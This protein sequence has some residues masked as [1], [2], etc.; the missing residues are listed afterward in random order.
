MSISSHS[1]S[2]FVTTLRPYPTIETGGPRFFLRTAIALLV[3]ALAGCTGGRQTQQS[4][5]GSGIPQIT[6]AA[7]QIHSPSGDMS[8]RVPKGWVML[9]A[10]QL[11]APQVF[12]VACNP[13]YTMSVIFSEAP[14]DNAA[15][16]IFSRDGLKGLVD[17]SFQRHLKRS[18]GRAVMAGET[19]EFAIGRRQFAAYSYSTDS[20]HTMTR[21]AV[22][23][24]NSHLYECAITHLT[25]S[26]RDLPSEKTVRNLHQLILGSIE[27]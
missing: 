16:G 20:L 11:E 4:D 7:D 1:L 27:W 15:R 8:A 23:F 13:E 10:E 24:T 5:D 17:A 9:D 25:F 19:E 14:V 21:V 26:A 12:A 6:F 2:S 22:F 18:Q 3:I